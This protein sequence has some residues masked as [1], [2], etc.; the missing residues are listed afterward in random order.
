[1]HALSQPLA[2][3]RLR[4][5]GG[6]CTIIDERWSY[7]MHAP[8]WRI[9]CNRE[10]GAWFSL[11]GKHVPMPAGQ[12]MVVPPWC[13]AQTGCSGRVHHVFVHVTIE[14]QEAW[15]PAGLPPF[16]LPLSADL[17]VLVERCEDSTVAPW[18]PDALARVA[19]AHTYEALPTTVRKRL[20]D[21]LDGP[22]DLAPAISLAQARL[23]LPLTVIELAAACGI[24]EDS[25]VRRFRR[26]L[27]CTPGVWLTR[28]RIGR[29]AELL[30]STD[31]PVESIAPQCGYADRAAFSRAFTRIMGLGP[32]AH[33]RQTRSW[34]P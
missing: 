26:R 7:P 25:L 24:S 22:D 8:W 1:M 11:A 14:G 27:G 21:A 12:V 23:H 16:V 13:P 5:A 4:I 30:E 19:L 18:W 20:R 6:A 32:A 17:Q 33:R 34:L 15:L 10:D 3:L 29:A 2:P 9:Y 28:L 31:D